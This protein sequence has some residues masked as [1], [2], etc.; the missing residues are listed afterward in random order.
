MLGTITLVFGIFVCKKIGAGIAKWI[1]T[2]F[3][4]SDPMASKPL[5]LTKFSDQF[6]QLIVHVV[7]SSNLATAVDI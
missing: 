5:L 7:R 2:N 3:V 6:W 4:A 1:S